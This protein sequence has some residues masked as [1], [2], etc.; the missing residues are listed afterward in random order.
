MSFSYF[1]QTPFFLVSEIFFGLSL[2]FLLCLGLYFSVA[3][4]EIR[5]HRFN[6]LSF[7]NDFLKIGISISIFSIVLFS[8]S[9]VEVILFESQF[10]QSNFLLNVKIILLFLLISTFCLSMD[11]YRNEGLD[12]FE[13]PLLKMLAIFMTFFVVS[14]NSFIS[15]YM[16]LEAQSLILY[17][18]AAFARKN[19]LSTEA[20]IKYFIL[21][22]S[23]FK[24][25]IKLIKQLTKPSIALSI[26]LHIII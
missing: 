9:Q 13:Y 12:L 19:E 16:S 20:G 15:F 14:S 1:S 10:I 8:L 24:T 6:I 25:I 22:L 23:S 7:S 11:Y 26:L 5:T 18:L 17:I 3:L 4:P 2:T 21:I